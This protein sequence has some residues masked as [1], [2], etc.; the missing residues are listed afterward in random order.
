MNC[1]VMFEGGYNIIF[2]NTTEL[3]KSIIEDLYNTGRIEFVKE[4]TQNNNKYTHNN[5]IIDVEEL[6]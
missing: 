6:K 1:K 2:N 5:I 4:N 3:Q